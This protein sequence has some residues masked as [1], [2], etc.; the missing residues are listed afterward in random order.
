MYGFLALKGDART[1]LG[2]TF[3]EHGETPGLGA[4]I[5]NPNW[6]A[7]W[8]NKIIYNTDGAT[9]IQVIKGQVDPTQSG[10]QHKVDAIAGAT[11]TSRGV[12]NLMRYWLGTQGFGPFL[13]RLQ[14]SNK[15]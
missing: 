14:T 10:A 8:V 1:V 13:T 3:Y 9:A 7:K 2:L 12:E 15:G 4:E 11:L 5:T 6:L